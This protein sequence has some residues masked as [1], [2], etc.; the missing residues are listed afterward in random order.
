MAGPTFVVNT[1]PVGCHAAPEPTSAITVQRESGAVQ[2]MDQVIRQPDGTWH[3]EVG[4]QCWTRTEPGPVRIY[5]ALEPAEDEAR[6]VRSPSLPIN[7]SQ[8]VGNLDILVQTAWARPEPGQSGKW[9][10]VLGM[11]ITNRGTGT[12][13]YDLIRSLSILPAG[14]TPES[15]PSRAPWLTQGR[16]QRDQSASGYVSFLLDRAT[17]ARAVQ[18]RAIGSSSNVGEIR[19]DVHLGAN[20]VLAVGTPPPTP[21]ATPSPPPPTPPPP[22]TAPVVA[23][24]PVAPATTAPPIARSCCRM[25][26]TGK[27]CGDSCINVNFTCRQ[28]PGC[29]CNAR[30]LDR[31]VNGNLISVVT[32]SEEV[33]VMTLEEWEALPVFDETVAGT[34]PGDDGTDPF[35]V[36]VL[37]SA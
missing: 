35:L 31:P 26:T 28:P 34:C 21:T 16:L 11:L 30:D 33:I 4:R 29:A 18:F 7:G 3:R 37:L 20:Q 17:H 12:Y 8:R 10:L 6:V 2:A 27:A 24:P 14:V 36:A 1:L 25:C 5:N 9:H 15:V 13:D 22:T 32:A 23:P 19:I